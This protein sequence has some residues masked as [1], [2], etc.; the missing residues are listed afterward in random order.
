MQ[1]VIAGILCLLIILDLWHE[2]YK[3]RLKF[4]LKYLLP[5]NLY[6][7]DI[8]TVNSEII[9][10]IEFN[11]PIYYTRSY[12]YVHRSNYINSEYLDIYATLRLTYIIK[13]SYC[14]NQ[15][16][17]DSRERDR[18]CELAQSFTNYREFAYLCAFERA[19]QELSKE[20]KEYTDMYGTI[21]LGTFYYFDDLNIYRYGHHSWY[22]REVSLRILNYCGKQL[23]KSTST[24]LWPYYEKHR[25]ILRQ[26]HKDGWLDL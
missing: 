25:E 16:N 12:D 5:K 1:Y 18:L 17:L 24:T 4:Q 3:H 9:K 7:R 20:Q 15:K 21:Q 23:N 22:D 11:L 19:L 14:K 26:I 13:K 6:L 8:A 2:S 10:E